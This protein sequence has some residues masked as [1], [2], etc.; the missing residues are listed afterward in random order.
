MSR[1]KF[2]ERSE[3]MLFTSE[4]LELI[5]LAVMLGTMLLPVVLSFA[6]KTRQS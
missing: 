2:L 6:R 3:V 1:F 5:S 4:K